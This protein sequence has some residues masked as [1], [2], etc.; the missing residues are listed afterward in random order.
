MFD[1]DTTLFLW[2]NASSA[3]PAWVVP[4]AR[5]ASLELPQWLLAGTVG[6]FIVGGRRVQRAVLNMM[7]AM[8]IAWLLARFAQHLWPMPRPFMLGLGSVWLP[9][10]DSAGFPSTHTSVAFAFAGAV[11]AQAQRRVACVAA[12]LAA[13][14]IAWSRVCLGLHFPFDVLV[15]ALVGLFSAWL[16]TLIPN[17]PRVARTAHE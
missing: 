14:F 1:F 2:L 16:G 10:G 17:L 6:A 9:H 4:L 12:L 15:G 13:V 3:A 11:C 8:A 7:A 5:F